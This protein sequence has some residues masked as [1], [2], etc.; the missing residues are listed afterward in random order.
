MATRTFWVRLEAPPSSGPE[1]TV[2]AD[3]FRIR[4]SAAKDGPGATWQEAVVEDLKEQMLEQSPEL[5]A[6]AAAPLFG[7]GTRPPLPCIHIWLPPRSPA[8]GEGTPA[9]GDGQQPRGPSEWRRLAA[10]D[11]LGSLPAEAGT[12]SWHLVT[13][14]SPPPGAKRGGG[15]APAGGAQRS[16]KPGDKPLTLYER[17]LADEDEP[18]QIKNATDL[19]QLYPGG[20]L[21]RAGPNELNATVVL[22]LALVFVICLVFGSAI[23]YLFQV[24]LPLL[25]APPGT[26]ARAASG[27]R[28]VGHV[29]RTEL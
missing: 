15:H 18:E 17:G 2:P 11:D 1:D 13:R 12:S 20:V 6:S 5:F 19:S 24:V 29:S 4:F 23:F 8:G 16:A 21:P 10:S 3:A 9:G 25:L 26:T 27:I 28:N 7:P 14:I 22:K